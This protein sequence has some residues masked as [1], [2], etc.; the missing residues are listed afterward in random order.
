LKWVSLTMMDLEEFKEG[1]ATR[2]KALRTK[3]GL[4]QREVGEGGGLALQHYQRLEAGTVNP[5]VETLIKA[6][7]GLGVTLKELLRFV[8]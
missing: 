1:L 5:S 3:K 8:R 4:S 7:D 6:A 2:L